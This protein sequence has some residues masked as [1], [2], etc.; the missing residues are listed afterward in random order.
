VFKE[1]LG[2]VPIFKDSPTAV[3]LSSGMAAEAVWYVA[4]SAFEL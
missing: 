2:S 3:Y 1:Y 4:Y